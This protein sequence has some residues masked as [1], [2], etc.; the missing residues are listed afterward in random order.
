MIYL[1]QGKHLEETLSLQLSANYLLN[2]CETF[3]PGEVSSLSSKTGKGHYSV[4]TI[5]LDRQVTSVHIGNDDHCERS[6]TAPLSFASAGWA[7][8]IYIWNGCG[9]LRLE[10]LL[11]V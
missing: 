5:E 8:S 4:C 2:V 6:A 10:F 9:A 7:A 11:T 3:S 1:L